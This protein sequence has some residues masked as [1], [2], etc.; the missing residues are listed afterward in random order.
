MVKHKN[1][2]TEEDMRGHWQQWRAAIAASVVFLAG[3][4]GNDKPATTPVAVSS[5]ATLKTS[6]AVPNSNTPSF[7]FDISHADNGKYYL[8]DRTNAAVDVVDTSSN[9]LIAQIKG[10][11]ASSFTGVGATTDVSGPDGLVGVPGTSTLYAGDVN[12]VKIVDTSAQQ[13]TGTIAINAG[14]HRVDEGCYDPDDNLVM[15]A[16]PAAS[17]PFVTFI[18]NQTHAIVATLPF[19]GSS[20]LEACA[21]DSNTKSF[22]INNDGT[23]ANPNGELDVIPA[24]SAVAAAPTITKTYPLGN[25]GPTGL[26]LGPNNDVL[27]GCDPAAPGVPLITLILDRTNGATLATIPFG[28]VDEVAYDPVT[29]RYF[30]PARDL[31]ASGVSASS[32]FTPE[33]GVI[34]AAS[35]KLIAQ[36][37]MG[38]GAHSVAVDGP[39]HQAY[40][41]F[42]PGAAAF[43]NGGILVYNTQ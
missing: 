31:T 6:I 25:C 39:T 14:G 9:A 4:G 20:G 2:P 38:D 35:R 27:V 12:S 42:A 16:A 40:V 33:L 29:N 19:A 3:C 17:P 8:A 7:S 11:G 43:P 23:T 18:S 15:F 37:A 30:L 41:P 13:V 32:G 26:V 28:G 10:S 1:L 34:D 36:P 22:L 5:L 24:S 21:Y